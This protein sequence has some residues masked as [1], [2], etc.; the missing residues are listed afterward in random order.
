M[1]FAL[2]R[3]V[4]AAGGEALTQRFSPLI[5]WIAATHT[6]KKPRAKKAAA[7]DAQK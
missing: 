7:K 6:P 4:K 2:A 5:D 1:L 3:A